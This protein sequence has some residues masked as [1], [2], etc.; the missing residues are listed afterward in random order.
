MFR[1][2]RSRIAIAYIA[3]I[4]V[5]ML[6][7][8]FYLNNSLQ[9][10][11]LNEIQSRLAVNARF[12]G[13]ILKN[14]I[15]DGGPIEASQ[16]FARQWA[17]LLENRVTIIDPNGRVIDESED[18]P[19][20]MDD[21]SSRP[22]IVEALASGEGSNTRF[23]ATTNYQTMYY[24]V[25]VK[26]DGK[27]VSIVRLALPLAQVN[28]S[29][30]RLQTS[31]LGATLL[32]CV[33]AGLLAYWIAANTTRPLL[34]LT[35]TAIDL[36]KSNFQDPDL[37]DRIP[38]NTEDEVGELTRSLHLMAIQLHA[39]LEAQEIERRKIENVFQVM[40][41]G[42]LIID[43]N[44]IVRMINPAA[45]S[46]F[47]VEKQKVLGRSLA[48]GLRHHQVVE[49]WQSSQQS[50]KPQSSLLEISTQRLYLEGFARPME[51]NPPADTLLLFNNL[52]RQ[53]H[54]ETIRRDFVSNLSHELRTPL[55]SLKALTETLQSGALDD[56]PAAH[57]FLQRMETEV[58][59][60]TQMVAEL[61]E[62]SRIESGRV[63]LQLKPVD[64][65]EV[66]T[67]AVDRLHLQAERV[68]LGLHV[69]CPEGLPAVLADFTRLEQVLVNL[70]HNAIKF[71]LPG[72]EIWVEASLQKGGNGH[73]GNVVFSIRD[74]G[75]GI[76]ADD[77]PRIFERFYKADR[78]RSS[79]G[80]GLG[81]AIARHTIEAHQGKIWAESVEGKGSTFYF[82]IPV[83]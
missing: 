36:S 27:T 50:G 6:G 46:M 79:G 7:L 69:R 14:Q 16:G 41:D 21:H 26:A 48:E 54:L 32:S 5:T 8:G 23:S 56:P 25:A 61:M 83:I 75:V 38:S 12:A 57:R 82:S 22:E 65:K 72:G 71:T 67:S 29:L 37:I 66:I 76:S 45:E 80:T 17:D 30:I 4:L 44:G 3:L 55:A 63:P 13:E 28:D 68:R 15:E 34:R 24:A 20:L 40:T 2:I 49:L 70:L 81:L 31:I 74:T 73:P 10:E 11:Y 35:K 42:V 64:A 58:D 19:A 39:Q 51:G 47:G 53:R 78:A 18:D 1:S 77:L 62:L 43:P 52:T 59:A 33:I 60:L 9:Q